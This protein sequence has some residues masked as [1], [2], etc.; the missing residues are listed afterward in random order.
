[1]QKKHVSVEKE[2]DCR[3]EERVTEN[4]SEMVDGNTSRPMRDDASTQEK[5]KKSSMRS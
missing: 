3:G 4:D 5:I 1:M 2:K